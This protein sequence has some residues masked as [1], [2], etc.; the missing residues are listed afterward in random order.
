MSEARLFWRVPIC[1]QSRSEGDQISHLI[2]A[3]WSTSKTFRT[4][5]GLDVNPGFAAVA[6]PTT[7]RCARCETWASSIK[8]PHYGKSHAAPL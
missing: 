7:K 8:F 2:P 6:S 4:F 1:N 3:S 5:C